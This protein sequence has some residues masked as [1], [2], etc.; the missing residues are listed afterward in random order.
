MTLSMLTI[1]L[2]KHSVT[3]NNANNA[4]H[5]LAI[6]NPGRNTVFTNIA[7]LNQA[8]KREVSIEVECLLSE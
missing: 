2:N 4:P 1:L 8:I 7:P 3:Q 6:E 5:R